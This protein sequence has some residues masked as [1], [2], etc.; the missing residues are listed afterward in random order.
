[1]QSTQDTPKAVLVKWKTPE[2]E[3]VN[4]ARII[5][6][7]KRR[8]TDKPIRICIGVPN[9]AWASQAA[10]SL[11]MIDIAA[12]PYMPV[13]RLEPQT[14]AALAAMD[15]LA[16]QDDESRT[17]LIAY[18]KTAEE[19]DKLLEQYGN[20]HGFALLRATGMKDAKQLHHM[21]T[22]LDGDENA[23]TISQMA[24]EQLEHPHAR[25][26]SEEVIIMD[27]RAINGTFDHLILVGCV[28]GMMGDSAKPADDQAL[29]AFQDAHKHATRDFIVSYFTRIDKAVADQARI[30]Y[31]RTK[32]E[33]GAL[34][35]MSKPTPFLAS[36]AS[37]RPSTM[38]GQA[39]LRSYGIN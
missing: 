34:L 39:L 19:C 18:G 5:G 4:I 23:A 14:K 25:E 3:L 28:D 38:S 15:F 7:F 30:N 20:A 33:N 9:N 26:D 1:M 32:T 12:V 36:K 22:L 8:R 10:R 17:A 13:R 2:D 16:K 6:K 37:M 35:A 31:S 29:A 27:Y 21:M 24:R 11:Q